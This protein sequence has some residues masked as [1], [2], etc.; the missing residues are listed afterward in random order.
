M[1]TRL[2]RIDNGSACWYEVDFPE[3]IEFRR[4]FLQE[5]DRDRFIAQSILDF[6]WIDRFECSP[7]DRPVLIFMEGVS[8]FKA[9]F[10]LLLLSKKTRK[11]SI[12]LSS[13]Q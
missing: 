8:P 4:K 13:N 10:D 1:R 9:I 6:T 3:V 7:A 5:S 2:A 12:F 11:F